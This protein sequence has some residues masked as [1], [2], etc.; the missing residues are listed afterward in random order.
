[1][2]FSIY[3]FAFA[4]I[5]S[6]LAVVG[7]CEWKRVAR[8]SCCGSPTVGLLWWCLQDSESKAYNF[9]A[10]WLALL[11]IAFGIGGTLVLTKVRRRP[12]ECWQQCCVLHVVFPQYRTAMAVGFLI[13]ASFMFSMQCL[14]LAVL[15]GGNAADPF[16]SSK[17]SSEK[18]VL[19]FAV[20]LFLLYVRPIDLLLRC[21]LRPHAACLCSLRVP[22]PAC[23]RGG[24]MM[25]WSVRND[26]WQQLEG[27]AA[28]DSCV[29]VCVCPQMRG[30]H[31]LN[32]TPSN[33][34]TMWLP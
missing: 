31:W 20:F 9:A 33:R 2:W 5:I 18:A 30:S 24:A 23:W 10:I 6:A 32:K 26:V 4:F 12:G 29:C 17:P 1:M 27:G 34:L 3:V 8:H 16:E 28:A 7:V 14:S 11:V 21:Y 13:G 22:S 25:L 19:A 15:S